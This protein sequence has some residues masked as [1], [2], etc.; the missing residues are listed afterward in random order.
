MDFREIG[1]EFVKNAFLRKERTRETYLE[2]IQF[3]K[4]N[5]EG[6]KKSISN[7]KDSQDT[8][9]SNITSSGEVFKKSK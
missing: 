6:T 9:K 3:C 8:A 4:D 5:I 1:T 7:I 2:A